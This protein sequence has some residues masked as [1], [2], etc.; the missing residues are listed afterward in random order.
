[1]ET[2][3]GDGGTTTAIH[4][5]T[6]K[7]TIAK[8]DLQIRKEVSNSMTLSINRWLGYYASH[9]DRKQNLS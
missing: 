9:E 8:F 7:V 6:H 5:L 2:K 1:M 4:T 3:L